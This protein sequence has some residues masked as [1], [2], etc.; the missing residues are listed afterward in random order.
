M[1]CRVLTSYPEEF[2]N[3]SL[4]RALGRRFQQRQ[5]RVPAVCNSYLYRTL[6]RLFATNKYLSHC[7][8]I[9]YGYPKEG[10]KGPFWEYGPLAFKSS[11]RAKRR[12]NRPPRPT[13]IRLAHR[14][15]YNHETGPNAQR[16]I[17]H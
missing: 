6:P 17:L 1:P 7:Y 10:D 16:R 12:Q 14:R 9:T 13:K 11:L 3:R 15:S 2:P 8:Q 4:G 5:R